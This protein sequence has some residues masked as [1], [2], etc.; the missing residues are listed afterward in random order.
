MFKK[1]IDFKNVTDKIAKNNLYKNGTHSM[2][3]IDI[4]KLR[5]G[6]NE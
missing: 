2:S 1:T 3:E 6:S 5:S 4:E